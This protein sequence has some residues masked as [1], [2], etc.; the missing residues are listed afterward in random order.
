MGQA[1]TLFRALFYLYLIII[2]VLLVAVVRTGGD[3]S[4]SLFLV[5]SVL[6]SVL[7]YWVLRDARGRQLRVFREGLEFVRSSS[8]TRVH[9]ND[10]DVFSFHAVRNYVNGAYTGLCYTLTFQLKGQE[11]RKPIVWSSTDNEPQEELDALKDRL[12]SAMAKRKM[13]ILSASGSVQWMK[14]ITM[15]WDKLSY[16]SGTFWTKTKQKEELR[17]DEIE[18]VEIQNA[19]CCIFRRGEKSPALAYPCGNPNFYPGF[20]LL[21]VLL[22]QR[23]D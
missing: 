10:I 17:F 12:A 13:E 3:W 18:R 8:S 22:K 4:V 19:N 14:G 5:L 9:F 2:P 15:H 7:F 16:E 11:G 1:G 23:N 20:L 6:S 21:S